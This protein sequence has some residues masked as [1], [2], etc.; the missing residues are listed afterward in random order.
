MTQSRFWRRL[1]IALFVAVLAFTAYH[2]ARTVSAAIYWHR[3]R[4]AISRS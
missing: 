4:D 2:A 3:H 1:L